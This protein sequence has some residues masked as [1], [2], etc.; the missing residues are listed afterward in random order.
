MKTLV[1]VNPKRRLGDKISEEIRYYIS[2]SEV[3]NATY[4][5]RLARGHWRIEKQLHWHL[6]I[7]FR[8][9]SCRARRGNAAGNLSAMRKIAL[10]RL[11]MKDKLSLKKRRFRAALNNNYLLKLLST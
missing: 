3:K 1:K 9:D 8:E 2:S 5:N 6:D 10:H 7:T 11:S 4:Y